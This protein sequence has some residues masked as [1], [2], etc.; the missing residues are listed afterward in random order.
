MPPPTDR[1]SRVA[2]D[3]VLVIDKPAGPTSHDVVARVRR[4]LGVKKIGHTGT[5]DPLATGVLP[6]V[7]GRATRVTQFL[8]AA[9]KTYEAT[10]ALGTSTDTYDA[11]GSACAAGA[12]PER[13]PTV[14]ADDASAHV[15]VDRRQVEEALSAFTGTFQQSPPPFSAKRIGGRRAYTLARQG[16]HVAPDP[17]T[18]HVDRLDVIALANDALSIRLTCS[19]GFYVRSLAHDIGLRLGCGAHLQALRR[20]RSG[21]FSIDEAIPL[22]AIEEAGSAAATHIRPLATLLPDLPRVVVTERGARR[23]AHGNLLLAADIDRRQSPASLPSATW[24]G[25]I[26]VFSL[27]G[28]LVAL[29][30]RRTDGALHPAVVLV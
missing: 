1:E 4:V 27:D 23:A 7:V 20:E 16:R 18:V 8:S 10:I 14:T 15:A 6:L 21:E 26:R 5:L 30:E 3:G 13:P 25:W 17:V 29:A 2:P 22:G 12:N 11:S 9:S 28:S 24:H 19:A